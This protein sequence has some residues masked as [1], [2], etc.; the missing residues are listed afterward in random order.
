MGPGYREEVARDTWRDLLQPLWSGGVHPTRR[1][2]VSLRG[3]WLV[4]L[5]GPRRRKNQDSRH[6]NWRETCG[7]SCAQGRLDIRFGGFSRRQYPSLGQREKDYPTRAG[8]L[9]SNRPLEPC[10]AQEIGH[11]LPTG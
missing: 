1:E 7:V 2:D 11:V 6:G 4:A 10:D 3:R 8:P 5:Q 9:L